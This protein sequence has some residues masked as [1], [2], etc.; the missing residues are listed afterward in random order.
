M[1]M[2]R[3]KRYFDKEFKEMVVNLC[4]SGKS[5][6]EIGDELRQSRYLIA[7]PRVCQQPLFN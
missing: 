5:A 3:E 1:N 2:K 4:L 6:K 7:E